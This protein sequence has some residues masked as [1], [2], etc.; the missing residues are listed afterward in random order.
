MPLE[1]L[2]NSFPV[3]G[4]RIRDDC[5]F[6]ILTSNFQAAIEPDGTHPPPDLCASVAEAAGL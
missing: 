6:L 3:S 4:F 1:T 5:G 2:L